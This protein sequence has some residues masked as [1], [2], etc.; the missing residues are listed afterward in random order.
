MSTNACI[1]ISNS[2]HEMDLKGI[3]CHWDGGQELASTLQ[4]H[5]N[6]WAHARELINDGDVSSVSKDYVDTYY[7]RGKEEWDR[8]KPTEGD[9][10]HLLKSMT[11]VEYFHIFHDGEWEFL[12]RDEAKQIV[13]EMEEMY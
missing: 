12:T 13:V 2:H 11:T 1:A 3:Y 7:S 10:D 5:Y 9:L 4:E 6:T 8:V